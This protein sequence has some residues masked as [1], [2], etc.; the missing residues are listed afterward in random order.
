MRLVN[1]IKWSAV[2]GG[3]GHLKPEAKRWERDVKAE[4][5]R[6]AK[7]WAEKRDPDA[8]IDTSEA[9]EKDQERVEK[10]KE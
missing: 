2:S 6:L 1:R 8:Q 10:A 3:G 9:R 5:D 7:R 4:A